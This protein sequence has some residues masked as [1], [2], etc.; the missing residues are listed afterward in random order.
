MEKED[1]KVSFVDTTVDGFR[2]LTKKSELIDLIGEC[3][4]NNKPLH[5][6]D[7]SRVD[8]TGLD[9]RNLTI[10]NIIFNS[11]TSHTCLSYRSAKPINDA[12]FRGAQISNVCFANCRFLR[13]N[14]DSVTAAIDNEI[15][16]AHN[17]NICLTDFFLCEF[18]QCRFRKANITIADFRYTQFS[19]CSL[20]EIEVN[21]GD[22]YMAA[23]KGT[24]SFDKCKLKECSITNTVFEHECIRFKSIE[25]LIQENYSDYIDIFYN[26]IFKVVDSKVNCK[27]YRR[28]QCIDLIEKKEYELPGN[29][30]HAESLIS[31][32]A[33]KVY[34]Q[35]S[36][37]Y[38]AKGFYRDSNKAYRLA[39]YDEVRG[40]RLSLC[41]GKKK[42]IC[43][44]IKYINDL[45][46]FWINWAFG[47]GYQ[48]WKVAILYAI[49]V[50]IFACKFYSNSNSYFSFGDAW[51]YSLRN[52]VCIDGVYSYVAG[53]LASWLEALFGLLLIG[54]AGFIIAN[55]I[56]NNY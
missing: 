32:E 16:N 6:L 52:S 33:S 20:G 50:S 4:T 45:I 49:L 56:R 47:F 8:L 48:L 28:D 55:R 21:Y 46:G 54:Y 23:F 41:D 42:K 9:F 26:S 18:A 17:T 13:C 37:I 43:T 35:L 29:R 30:L 44:T 1:L 38:L 36:G 39:K 15:K 7:I 22:F 51:V 19:D 27:W 25:K 3:R 24:T 11:C 34:A 31:L 53:P 5:D 14:F 40:Y 12:D 10:Y 2:F